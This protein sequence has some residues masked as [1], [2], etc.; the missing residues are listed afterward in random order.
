[1]AKRLSDKQIEYVRDAIPL[2]RQSDKIEERLS[3]ISAGRATLTGTPLAISM[4]EVAAGDLALV[5]LVSD[6][7][8]A[9]V[10]KIM[11]ACTKG[12]LTI[13]GATITA[14]NAV[15]SYVIFRA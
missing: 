15:V 9:P 1:M 5:Q 6:D 10:G 12:V 2:N 11:A 8:G 14:G 4:T 7:T 3:P 13:T